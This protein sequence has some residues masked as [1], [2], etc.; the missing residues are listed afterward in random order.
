MRRTACFDA[1]YCTVPY[2]GWNAA[3]KTMSRTAIAR[4]KY[5][6]LNASPGGTGRLFLDHEENAAAR[7]GGSESSPRHSP[8]GGRR[9]VVSASTRT[10]HCLVFQPL[11]RFVASGLHGSTAQ[12]GFSGWI[13]G[14]R[15][16]ALLTLGCTLG[17]SLSLMSERTLHRSYQCP[18]NILRL[19]PDLSTQIH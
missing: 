18:V 13:M 3:I 19:T 10:S 16:G 4:Y 5:R 6:F 1:V 11:R 9:Q 12:L 2:I 17:L 7:H 14:S 8:K 15:A